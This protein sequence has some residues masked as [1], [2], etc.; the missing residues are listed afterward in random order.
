MDDLV[1]WWDGA[2]CIIWLL[3]WAFNVQK[4]L[5]F[6]ILA[7]GICKLTSAGFGMRV[8]G[9]LDN[10]EILSY[11]GSAT[12]CIALYKIYKTIKPKTDKQ[13]DVS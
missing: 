2:L 8:I 12:V 11:I 4:Y 1:I 9:G 10:I 6:E 7:P 13:T 3:F 5:K